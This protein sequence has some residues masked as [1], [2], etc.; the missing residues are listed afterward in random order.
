[1]VP[2]TGLLINSR[3]WQMVDEKTGEQ[4]SGTTLH[5]A[6][7]QLDPDSRLKGFDIQKLTGSPALFAT[8]DPKMPGQ[9]V[10]VQCEMSVKGTRVKLIP[11]SV[12]LAK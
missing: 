11:Q 2:I 6:S 9:Q 3:S 1:M 4:R 7:E 12:S 8:I 10:V 5:L